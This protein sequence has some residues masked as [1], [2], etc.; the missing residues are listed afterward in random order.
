MEI[1]ELV[2]ILGISTAGIIYNEVDVHPC[3]IILLSLSPKE[4]PDIHRKFISKFRLLISDIKLKDKIIN[5]SSTIVIKN[6]LANW[7]QKEMEEDF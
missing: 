5:A 7:D 6:L 1:D 4:N 2:C 3:H